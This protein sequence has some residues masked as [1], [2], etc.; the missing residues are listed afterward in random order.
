MAPKSFQGKKNIYVCEACKGHIVTVDRD[1]G[2]T[3]FMTSCY[4]KEGCS[5]AMRSSM[6]EVSDQ[7]M[8]AGYEW[9][10]P[11]SSEITSA[12]LHTRDHVSNGGLLLRKI[13]GEPT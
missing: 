2:V 13:E 4:A 10:R 1:D 7:T 3:P 9:Y 6:Y 8:R 5:G 12:S 11:D